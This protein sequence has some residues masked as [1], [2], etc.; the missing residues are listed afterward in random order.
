[1]SPVLNSAN[2]IRT[3]PQ[4]KPGLS[5]TYGIETVR[6]SSRAHNAPQP[7]PGFQSQTSPISAAI[8][9]DGISHDHPWALDPTFETSS[10]TLEHGYSSP[11][12]SKQ[13]YLTAGGQIE[14]GLMNER[15]STNDH[16]H[17]LQLVRSNS[18][19]KQP[20]R[21]IGNKQA[22]SPNSSP[23]HS[24][25]SFEG[26]HRRRLHT[27]ADSGATE[28]AFDAA[29]DAAVEAAYGE[30]YEPY[31]DRRSDWAIGPPATVWVN[32]VPALSTQH[33]IGRQNVDPRANSGSATGP[34]ISRFPDVQEGDS[35]DEERVLEELT[36]GFG[37]RDLKLEPPVHVTVPRGS[38]SSGFSNTT[39]G[40]SATS[41]MTAGTSLSTVDE[42]VL[43]SG[44]RKYQY[45]NG[46]ASSSAPAPPPQGPL[47]LPPAFA[48]SQ[49]RSAGQGVAL[50]TFSVQERR[51][52]GP[53]PR[54]LT[55][56]TAI[57]P[58]LGINGYSA[59]SHSVPST[60]RS[61]YASP[62][63]PEKSD[64]RV[65]RPEKLLPLATSPQGAS[66]QG[67][68]RQI[69]PSFVLRSPLGP[70]YGK[71]SGIQ[72]SPEGYTRASPQS[73]SPAN[74]YF[75]SKTYD[76]S[77]VKKNLSSMS[78]KHKPVLTST[79]EDVYTSQEAMATSTFALTPF[80]TIINS[81]K[82]SVPTTAQT[83]PFRG[84]IGYFDDAAQVAN[85]AVSQK[86]LSIPPR[87]LEPCP[88]S[89]MLRPLWLM[90]CLYEV[91]T[92]PKGGYLSEKLFVPREVWRLKKV[93]LKHIDDKII[94][95]QLLTDALLKLG[96]LNLLNT[97]AILHEM[98]SL[99]HV[100]DQAQ[101]SLS[102][103]LGG[104]V[105]PH[106]VSSMFKEA[107][108]SAG[109]LSP[110]STAESYQRE[111]KSGM[112]MMASWRKLRGKAPTTHEAIG[113]G[114]VSSRDSRQASD[115]SL[116]SVPMTSINGVTS[117]RQYARRGATDYRGEGPNAGYMSAVAKLCS[118][119]QVLGK[120]LEFFLF[121]YRY[122]PHPSN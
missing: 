102:R 16:T 103:K 12:S 57:D 23:H 35:D 100:L 56:E 92:H 76:R 120:L 111:H 50:E 93:K 88:E 78:L 27:R 25:S 43:V 117:S 104:D 18:I 3:A 31:D 109:D 58:A 36:K 80:S 52:P 66:S 21:E 55:I 14:H 75:G 10:R 85:K 70:N 32:P 41:S 119:V 118:A 47:P 20:R 87:P 45:I 24:V 39:F 121:T 86:P 5:N 1:M 51:G 98:Q 101:A 30:G 122:H 81:S 67:L 95:M 48:M 44:S 13:P 53:H 89:P 54:K 11:N 17:R 116:P 19:N 8:H 72:V 84:R 77:H 115:F 73:G 74:H 96:A 97:D 79:S 22:S 7:L 26:L 61:Q 33:Q 108:A 49:N 4:T 114:S 63:T 9:T 71:P 113:M 60:G 2:L 37:L 82:S 112:S 105:G 90:R 6:P 29:L 46:A 64:S 65:L 110:A 68:S 59:E 40:S 91:V 107:S 42:A 83:P 34:F 106:T 38:D 94:N 15:G 62:V 69:S 99:E 28:A